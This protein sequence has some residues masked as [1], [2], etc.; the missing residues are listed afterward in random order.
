[1]VGPLPQAAAGRRF[2]DGSSEVSIAARSVSKAF[3][4]PHE[5]HT[6]AKHRVLR[7]L[8]HRRYEV[9][10]AL[11]DVSFEVRRG[12][13]FG[14]VG[15]NGSGKSTLLKC[16]SR[17]Y[18]VDEGE[19]EVSGRLAPFIELGVGFNPELTARDN[20]VINAVLLGLTPALAR[21]RFDEIIAFAE[22][23]PFVDMKLKNFSTGMSMRLAFAVTTQVDADVLLF[24]EV[25]AVGDASFEAK[26]LSYLDWL[27]GQG[28]TVV[29]V[30]HDMSA[31]EHHCDRGMLLDRGRVSMIGDADELARAYEEANRGEKGSVAA[32]ADEAPLRRHTLP[33]RSGLSLKNLAALRIQVPRVLAITKTLAVAEFKLK[34]FDTW[35]SYLWIL[36][37][38]LAFFGTLYFVFTSIGR[39]DRGIG[40]YP[41][42]LLSS[43]VLWFFFADSTA[44]AVYALVTK[45]PLLR[46]VP[47]PHV[48]IPLSVVAIGLFDL[49]MSA[50]AVLVFMLA[51]G[52]EPRLTWLELIPIL[53]LYTTLVAGAA[54][55]L[56][57]LY[58]RF[59]DVDHIWG[60]ARQ[61]LFY[62]S[63][64]FY[65]T[66]SFPAAVR[67]FLEA[68][69]LAAAFTQL[70][71]AVIDA[72]A[73]SLVTAD[74]GWALALVPV[75]LVFV[76]FFLGLWVFNRESP[77]VPE[78]V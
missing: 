72:K 13:C 65:V 2:G 16:I 23:E 69:P 49:G 3:R 50:L 35:L 19:I 63:P 12:E 48:A 29:L 28:R 56:S 52:V 42:Y 31:I 15:R 6:T 62:A 43:L 38:P 44:Q 33:R 75:A 11:D 76:I 54:M 77:T 59:R 66:A 51:T 37:R 20:V 30:T 57:A 74:G 53:L 36:V 10:D 61:I 1:M 18:R 55:L 4:L 39:F 68:N 60:L 64:I 8:A 46:R 58:V 71:H 24:D 32:H 22:L 25:I 26:C 21:A 45:E 40:H 5:R 17:I 34:Y 73:P 41:I 9:L 67:P 47:F 7:P 14:I 78:N 27:R 70:R